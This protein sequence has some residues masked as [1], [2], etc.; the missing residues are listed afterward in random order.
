MNLT[1]ANLYFIINILSN[2][3]EI[4]MHLLYQHSIWQKLKF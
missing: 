2:A 3:I 4:I 1:V